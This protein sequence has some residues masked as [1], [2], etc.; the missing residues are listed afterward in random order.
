VPPFVTYGAAVAAAG[1]IEDHAAGQSRQFE[2]ERT[3]EG[4]GTGIGYR[5][6]AHILLRNV[7]RH[8]TLL[9]EVDAVAGPS[10]SVPAR[11][12]RGENPVEFRPGCGAELSCMVF[13]SSSCVDVG[14]G[15]RPHG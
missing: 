10:A 14:I 8:G 1:V 15:F 9:G 12:R 2:L 13:M 6:P 3:G 11:R 7:V 5:A 4:V